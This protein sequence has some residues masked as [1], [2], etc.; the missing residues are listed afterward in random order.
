MQGAPRSAGGYRIAQW[1]VHPA[2]DTVSCGGET[3][4][5]EPKTMGVLVYLADHAAEV[6][7]Q[8]DL[9]AAVWSDVVVSPQSVYQSIAQLRRVF[10]DDARE[11]RYI[12]TVPRK[13]YRL[14]APV[15]RVP[16][17]FEAP[18][19]QDPGHPRAASERSVSGVGNVRPSHLLKRWPLIVAGAV[20]VVASA[21]PLWTVLRTYDDAFPIHIAVL[22]FQDL[23]PQHDNVPFCDGLT[24][25]L[26]SSLGRLPELRVTGRT[27]SFLF[28]DPKGDSKEIGA[29]LAVSRLLE[30]SV[31]RDGSRMR[32]TAELVDAAQGVQL[33]SQSFDRATGETLYIQ[34]QIAKDVVAALNLRLSS[35]SKQR[36]AQQPSANVGAYELYLLGRYQQ[37]QRTP[38]AL[39]RAVSYHTQAIALDPKFSLAYAG[40][41][42]A[43]M[44]GYYY[45]NRSLEQT[46]ALV[47]PSVEQALKL[48]PG[49]AE[50]Y[51]AR[52]VLRTEQWRLDE[53]IS[54]LKK[55]V[56]LRPN[57]AEAL[58]RLGGAYEYRAQ[59][60][61]ALA[62]YREA[63]ELDPLHVVLHIRRCLVQQNLGHYDDAAK[64][65]ARATE[66][67]PGNPN[68]YWTTGLLALSQGSL[69]GAI[70]GYRK[71][72]AKAPWRTDLLSQLGWLL[73]DV[74][75]PEEARKAFDTS[76]AQQGADPVYLGLERAQFFVATGSPGDLD[77]YLKG[78]DLSSTQEAQPLLYAALLELVADNAP[79][80]RNLVTRAA[81]SIHGDD[82]LLFQN[83]WETRWGRAPEVVLALTARAAGDTEG[84]ERYLSQLD[85]W[86]EFVVREGH[87][88]AGER[89]LR[90][91]TAALRNDRTRALRALEDAVGLGWRRSWWLRADPAFR[92]LRDDPRFVALLGRIDALNAPVRAHITSE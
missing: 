71:A 26:M 90:A 10:G 78:I 59:P 21:W 22:P 92:S 44:A 87:V 45:Q 39:E 46:A 41:A 76:L 66:L 19:T 89:Y 86:L 70:D 23:S 24:D 34:E 75:L 52:A 37:L 11:P 16:L 67:Q 3:V 42:D 60:R 7:T 80:S 56:A 12:A 8:N 13:G 85:R 32:V 4:K 61:E 25:E 79:Q 18:R 65:C 84:A 49:L 91:S 72:L 15:E 9:D 83:V 29:K 35:T 38:D 48:D 50:A 40:R 20:A 57:Y 6:V 28:R 14:I 58:I 31:R 1:L 30:G 54:D 5:L 81:S 69:D 82:R 62:A 73:L 74:G 64:A 36:L 47:E 27:S 88:W 68:P 2:L 51:A 55:A 77:H 33:W 17:A 53:A 43:Y 63:A